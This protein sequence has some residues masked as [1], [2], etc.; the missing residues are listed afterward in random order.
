M[1]NCK[2]KYQRSPAA[3]CD[4][5]PEY[6]KSLHTFIRVCSRMKE[7]ETDEEHEDDVCK[8]WKLV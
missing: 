5:E 2:K 7:R 4:P 6:T 1:T 3:Y 8:A